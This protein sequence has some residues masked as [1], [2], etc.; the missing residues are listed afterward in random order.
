MDK[1]KNTNRTK[2]IGESGIPEE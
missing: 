2:H 1:K